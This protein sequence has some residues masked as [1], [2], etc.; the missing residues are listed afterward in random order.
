[1]RF[2]ASIVA[3]SLLTPA[4]TAHAACAWVLWGAYGKGAAA[5]SVAPRRL[6]ADEGIHKA[7]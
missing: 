1:M 2:V 5:G 4:A 7:S 3:F 6:S